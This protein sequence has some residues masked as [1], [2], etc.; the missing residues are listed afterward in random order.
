MLH[1]AR[2]TTHELSTFSVSLRT[3]I[4]RLFTKLL[5]RQQ[6]LVFFKIKSE[7]IINFFDKCIHL[8][9][10]MRGWQKEA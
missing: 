7:K 8:P 5:S 3:S 9:H 4:N 10:E 1:I 6:N 2:A